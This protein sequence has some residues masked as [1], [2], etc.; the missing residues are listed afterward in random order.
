M[1]NFRNLKTGEIKSAFSFREEENRIYIK[2]TDNGKEYGYFKTNIE[3]LENEYKNECDLPFIVYSLNKECYKCHKDTEILT[4]ITFRDQPNKSLA[5]PWD[6]KRLLENQDI[7][8]HIQDPS[9]EYYGLNV[10]GDIEKYDQLL[11]N[12]YPDKIRLE[13]SQTKK[14]MYPMNICSHCG[15]KQGWYF[16]FRDVNK[17][18]SKMQ[19]IDIID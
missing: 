12:K 6:K 4:Y 8:A 17:L 14:K 2:F 5:F 16:V 18:I 19:K 15:A 1:I 7:F 9:I 13:F 10:I 11:M 3:I